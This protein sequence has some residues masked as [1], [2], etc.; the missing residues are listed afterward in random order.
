MSAH[1]Y[2]LEPC[3]IDNSDYEFNASYVIALARHDAQTATMIL[4]S[5]SPIRA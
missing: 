3:T 2:T 5:T 4:P 1:S